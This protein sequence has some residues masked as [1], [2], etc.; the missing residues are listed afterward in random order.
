MVAIAYKQGLSKAELTD[1]YGFPAPT[2]E[3]WFEEFESNSIDEIVDEIERFEL[4]GRSVKPLVRQPNR[5]RLT[6][7][8]Y[9]VIQDQGWDIDDDDLFE[10]ASAAHLDSEDYGRIVVERGES[11]LEAVERRGYNWPYACRGGAC[12]N[13]AVYLKDGE[14]AMPGQQ[15]L[16]E[17]AIERGARLTCVGVPVTDHVGIIYNAKYIDFL[18]ELRLPA[19]RFSKSL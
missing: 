2:V 15:I 11:I 10:K 8:N 1:W 13:C 19:T 14:I 17:D 12:S 6:Y 5:S 7:L 4:P 18:D 16:P 3:E 9:E